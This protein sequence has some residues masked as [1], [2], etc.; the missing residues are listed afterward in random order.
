MSNILN[1]MAAASFLA[2]TASVAMAQQ[3]NPNA[4]PRPLPPATELNQPYDTK[5]EPTNPPEGVGSRALRP[6][7][8]EQPT[9]PNAPYQSRIERL[10]KQGR[11]GQQN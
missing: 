1:T 4:D 7:E 8:D 10:D 9:D 3:E 2:M 6:L 5:S 11:G